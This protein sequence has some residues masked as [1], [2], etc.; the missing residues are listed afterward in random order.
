[1][2]LRP[3]LSPLAEKNVRLIPGLLPFRFPLFTALHLKQRPFFFRD[4]TRKT[5]GTPLFIEWARFFLFSVFFFSFFFSFP[6]CFFSI[7][8]RDCSRIKLV[9]VGRAKSPNT[10]SCVSILFSQRAEPF[11]ALL[12]RLEGRHGRD[13]LTPIFPPLWYAP[14]LLASLRS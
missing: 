12:M 7:C 2:S 4:V 10:L 5:A 1:M 11:R 8:P 9:Y 3:A 13:A 6:A 14:D